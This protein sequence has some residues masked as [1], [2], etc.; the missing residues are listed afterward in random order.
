MFLVY[1]RCRI[2]F[3]PRARA[4]R[5]DLALSEFPFWI[6]CR[7]GE[8]RVDE[9]WVEGGWRMGKGKRERWEDMNGK[10]GFKEH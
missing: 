1:F 9:G 8:D 3:L 10:A 5:L 7:L 4:P 6:Q 2:R